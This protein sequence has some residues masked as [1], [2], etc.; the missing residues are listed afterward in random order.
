M[1]NTH[2]KRRDSIG[3]AGSLAALSSTPSPLTT[4]RLAPP[5]CAHLPP[6][7]TA[8]GHYRCKPAATLNHA[9][10]PSKV[11]ERTASQSA[12]ATPTSGCSLASRPSGCMGSATTSSTRV[13]L[14]SKVNQR[15]LAT[16][17]IYLDLT[18]AA[19]KCMEAKLYILGAVSVL[20]LMVYRSSSLDNDSN[21]VSIIKSL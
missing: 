16:K 11:S 10:W 12:Q 1:A 18:P 17:H 15:P 6:P 8:N 20:V 7:L 21:K 19:H 4:P 9:R 2:V 14:N 3:S 13:S 5:L